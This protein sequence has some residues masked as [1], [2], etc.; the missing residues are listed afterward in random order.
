MAPFLL[1]FAGIDLAFSAAL[2]AQR[3]A[4]SLGGGFL[5]CL[6]FRLIHSF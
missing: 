5:P 4:N 1:S 3:F 2:A 6:N